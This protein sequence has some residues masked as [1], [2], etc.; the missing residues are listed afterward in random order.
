MRLVGSDARLFTFSRGTQSTAGD[1]LPDGTFGELSTAESSNAQGAKLSVGDFF[2]ADGSDFTLTEGQFYPITLTEVA[3]ITG[4]DV[5]LE[6]AQIDT[7]VLDDE[8]GTS[9]F[10]RRTL[11]GSINGISA[12]ASGANPLFERSIDEIRIQA[13]NVDRIP[14]VQGTLRLAFAFGY[15]VSG[16]Y[17]ILWLPGALIGSLRL[18]VADQQRQEFTC[19]L[20]L[21]ADPDVTGRAPQ[22]LTVHPA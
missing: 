9:R 5:T 20:G 11:S 12:I 21:G 4:Y 10:G 1:D 14:R 17:R 22:L 18:G 19:D 3:D 15:Q 13:A 8:V 7:S 2:Y 16:D 6:Q